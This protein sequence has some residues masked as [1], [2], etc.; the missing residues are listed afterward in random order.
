MKVLDLGRKKIRICDTFGRISSHRSRQGKCLVDYY[1]IVATYFSFDVRASDQNLWRERDSARK[2][3]DREMKPTA[4][5]LILGLLPIRCHDKL[6]RDCLRANGPW[7]FTK[8][9]KRSFLQDTSQSVVAQYWSCE[10]LA[11]RYSSNGSTTVHS[12]Y[13]SL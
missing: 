11:Y 5:P 13:P 2:I 10:Q 3:T 9:Y 6:S 12:S 7:K 4:L 8:D 1:V